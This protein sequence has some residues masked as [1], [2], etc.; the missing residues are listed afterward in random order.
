MAEI[1]TPLDL[2]TELFK[3]FADEVKSEQSMGKK[4]KITFVEWYHYIARA[5]K[6]FPEGFST[7]ITKLATIGDNFVM[8][9]RVIDNQTGIYHEATGSAFAG[10]DKSNFGGA[11]AEAESQALRRAFAKF[12]LGLEMYMDAEDF[13]QADPT[14]K[15]AVTNATKGQ[16]ARMKQLV[17]ACKEAGKLK[18]FV[19][20]LREK[21]E[22]VRDKE[23]H[24]DFAIDMLENK[25]REEGIDIPDPS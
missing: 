13:D 2:Y 11:N 1:K 17:G 22:S 5:W 10:K 20:E 12:G 6:T 24:T 18:D 15:E 7:E 23:L 9:V 14:Q 25:M 3:P 4:G 21:V 19:G 8:V 16:I